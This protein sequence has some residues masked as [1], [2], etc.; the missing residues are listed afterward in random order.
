MAA[1]NPDDYPGYGN[2]KELYARVND[3][4]SEKT[5]RLMYQML[6]AGDPKKR[7]YRVLVG[8]LY[9]D[10]QNRDKKHGK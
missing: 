3:A 5:Y 8:D 10:T 7:T 1:A 6:I 4:T 2:C 9:R